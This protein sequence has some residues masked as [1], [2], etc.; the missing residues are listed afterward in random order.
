MPF[1]YY[2]ISYITPASIIIP[3][4]VGVLKFRQLNKPL[5][6]IF[7]LV[8]L[9]GIANAT[10]ILL[11]D[12]YHDRDTTNLFHYYTPID[13]A[14]ISVFYSYLFW[15]RIK[16]VIVILIVALGIFCCINYKYIQNGIQVN[17]YPETVEAII[18][19]AYSVIYL[20]KQSSVDL[21]HSWE[22]NPFNWVNISFLIY[23]GCGL[24]MFMAT[25]YLMKASMN[26]NII[27]W[28]VFDSILVVESVL[29]AIGFYKCRT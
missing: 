26:V 20:Y 18:I 9:S 25:N 11:I 10:N 19:I 13:F 15:G 7:W 28:S 29:L 8:V 3:I 21:D 16:K 23:Y 24:F 1:L 27:V 2:Y 14:F 5:K 22:Q 6:V 12:Y 17:T 4:I